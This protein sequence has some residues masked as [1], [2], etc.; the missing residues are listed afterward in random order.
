MKKIFYI[1]I[2]AL[3]AMG[4]VACESLKLG[5][6]G[7]SDAPETSGATLD[8]LF[9]SLADADKVLA[10]S[11][12]KLRPKSTP[13][14]GKP[15]TVYHVIRWYNL[16]ILFHS[17]TFCGIIERMN[18]L[19]RSSP[20]GS[21]FFGIANLWRREHSGSGRAGSRPDA[22]RHVYRNNLLP[23]APSSAL[24]DCG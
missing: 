24:G 14:S 4:T 20:A 19:G 10:S 23:G 2:I 16:W 22:S 15:R 21:E 12:Q 8:T 6:A 1:L 5:D 11:L 13:R 7:L 9:R 3:F 17:T 18:R